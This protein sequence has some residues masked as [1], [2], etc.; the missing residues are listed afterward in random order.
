MSVPAQN[1]SRPLC[2]G[3]YSRFC[4]CECIVHLY[5]TVCLSL[6]KLESSMV[7][8]CLFKEVCTCMQMYTHELP[9]VCIQYTIIYTHNSMYIHRIR[10]PFFARTAIVRCTF[11]VHFMYVCI[12]IFVRVY[13]YIY[14][15]YI[16]IYICIHIYIYM[17]ICIY[18]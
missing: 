11:R 5:T 18:I 3:V 9:Y 6:R 4:V 17:Y 15:I 7:C 12:N 13:I 10:V 8:Q 1:W 2:V 14:I 16:N